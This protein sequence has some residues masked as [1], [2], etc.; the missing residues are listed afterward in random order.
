MR[1]VRKSGDIAHFEAM[2][3]AKI[4][5]LPLLSVPL[6]MISFSPGTLSLIVKTGKINP[7]PNI[8]Y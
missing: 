1:T 3:D 2:F 6:S 4:C 8:N 7:V 5:C